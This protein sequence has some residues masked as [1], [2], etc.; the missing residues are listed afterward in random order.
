MRSSGGA[1]QLEKPTSDFE[2]TV[3]EAFASA[4]N[5]LEDEVMRSLERFRFAFEFRRQHE[6]LGENRKDGLAHAIRRALACHGLAKVQ[7]I[8]G[9]GARAL[10]DS[11]KS[12]LTDAVSIVVEDGYSV[13]RFRHALTLSGAD[14]D[15]LTTTELRDHILS[16]LDLYSNRAGSGS[17]IEPW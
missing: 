12:K 10:D 9:A 16:S 14:P 8:E 7:Q 17:S 1:I 11:F 6:W 2:R 15:R 13:S 5:S 3:R 4:I